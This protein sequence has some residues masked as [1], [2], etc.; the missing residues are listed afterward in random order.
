LDL[1]ELSPLLADDSGL[2][3][4]VMGRRARGEDPCKFSNCQM[5]TDQALGSLWAKYIAASQG[6]YA[7]EKDPGKSAWT[8]A[9]DSEQRWTCYHICYHTIFVSN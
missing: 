7:E 5:M 2:A 3:A 6:F 1:I 4:D 8:L 9:D